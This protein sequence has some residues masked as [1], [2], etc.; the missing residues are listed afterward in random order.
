[1]NK[2]LNLILCSLII[3]N[4]SW[5]EDKKPL[6]VVSTEKEMLEI[7]ESIQTQLE[8]IGSY[9]QQINSEYLKEG[10]LT[11]ASLAA[12]TYT[13]NYAVNNAIQNAPGRAVWGET[14]RNFENLFDKLDGVNKSKF[15]NQFEYYLNIFKSN[16]DETKDYLKEING[17]S[18][19]SQDAYLKAKG[20][21][22]AK[23]L[24]AQVGT[25]VIGLYAVNKASTFLIADSEI[26]ELRKQIENSEYKVKQLQRILENTLK[27][28][29]I[30]GQSK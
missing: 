10:A 17:P 26:R 13:F 21:H 15:Q 23:G 25:I 6:A 14:A 4:S 19:P 12:I 7:R 30:E 27:L 5:A 20:M 9:K 3:C 1:M 29:A 2:I 8:L 16:L 22:I 24:F 18:H 28:K 11:I